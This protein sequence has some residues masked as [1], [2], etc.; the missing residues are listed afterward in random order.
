MKKLVQLGGALAAAGLVI[1]GG[2]AYTA[3]N[4]MN[5]DPVGGVGSNNVTGVTVDTTD[6]VYSANGTIMQSVEYVINEDLSGKVVTATITPTG[7]G[8][9]SVCTVSLPSTILCN[10][11]A[12]LLGWT[13]A[14]LTNISLSVVTTETT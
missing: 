14:G 6:Y 7:I 8:A 12:T 1:A 11:D 5:A 13:V 9:S 3:S 2:S 4:T 10:D